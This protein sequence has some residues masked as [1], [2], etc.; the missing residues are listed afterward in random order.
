M[1]NKN[2][3]DIKE[4]T[5]TTKYTTITFTPDF[6]KFGMPELNKDTQ[7]III[8]SAF[9]IA[10]CNPKKSVILNGELILFN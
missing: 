10:G 5:E 2:Q 7:L 8:K 4:I 9:D 6:N 1:S 3:A